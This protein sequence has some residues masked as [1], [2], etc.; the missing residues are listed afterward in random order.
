MR[1]GEKRSSKMNSKQG[2]LEVGRGAYIWG[3]GGGPP[4]W[5]YFLVQVDKP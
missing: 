2:K 4:N 5:M 1:L 3:W